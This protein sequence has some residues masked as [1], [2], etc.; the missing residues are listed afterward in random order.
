MTPRGVKFPRSPIGLKMQR[1]RFLRVLIPNM[2]LKNEWGQQFKF[3]LDQVEGD[4]DYE[5]RAEAPEV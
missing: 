3:Q 4:Q 1:E 2:L 5:G